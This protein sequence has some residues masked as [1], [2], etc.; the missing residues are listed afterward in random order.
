VDTIVVELPAHHKALADVVLA[1]SKELL[2]IE[3]KT[4]GG[5]TVDMIPIEESVAAAAARL[6]C[7]ML[8]EVLRQLDVDA[9]RVVIGGKEYVRVGRYPMTYNGMPGSVAIERSIFRLVTERNG[10]TVDPIA[11]RAGLVGGA[12]LPAA[13]RAMAQRLA[14]GTSREAEATS[15]LE[16]RLPY[17]RTSFEEVAHMVGADVVAKRAEI[18]Q[19]L[20][21]ATPVPKGTK[22]VS[23]ALDRSA[24]AFE[25][26]RPR[27]RGRPKK[28]APKR[29]IKRVFHMAWSGTLT[30]NDHEGTVLQT[31]HY[32][33][34]PA[35]GAMLA[36]TLASD[37]MTIREKCP[38]L[39]IVIL[40]DGAHELWN[41]LEPYFKG[42][43]D[44]TSTVDFWHLAE[45]L[46]AAAK[47]TSQTPEASVAGWRMALL[48]RDLAPEEILAELRESGMEDV[49]VGKDKP[50]HDAITYLANHAGRM[51]YRENRRRGLPIGSGPVEANAKSL[52]TVRMTRPGAR[53]KPDTADHV[54]QL[55]SHVL[56]D[57]L[58]DACRMALPQPQAVRRAA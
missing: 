36:E 55:R 4:K 26:A 9:E 29:P 34:E 2:E 28:G 6:E 43:A 46:A 50:V 11:L 3:P 20:I 7:A 42:I 19:V 54:L 58:V 24:M 12:W 37:V 45:K 51:R 52:Y 27:P 44:V 56:S 32:G 41:L 10:K 49:A 15:K 17:S 8:S 31:I 16:K 35:F 23:I 39:P 30:F 21:E 14:I 38:E 5:R 53:W 13:A 25:E 40:C 1:A 18:E 33:R 48:N 57:R 22:S 47:L